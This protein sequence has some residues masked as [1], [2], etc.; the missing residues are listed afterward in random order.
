MRKESGSSGVLGSAYEWLD[1]IVTAMVLV[2]VL[3]TFVFGIVSVKGTS[4]ENTFMDTDKVIISNMFYTPQKGDVVI[5]SLNHTNDDS[6]S[7]QQ[8][9]DQRIIKRIIAVG[10]QKVRIDFDKGIVY[11]DGIAQDE[12]YTKTP[13]TLKYDL[14]FS[15]DVTVPE[16]HVF[17]MGDNRNGSIDSRSS[18]IGMIDQRYILGKVLFRFYSDKDYFSRF[19]PVS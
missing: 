4:M 14:D 7:A 15:E 16:G 9:E 11:V 12:P 6:L 3:F 17:V 2:V 1:S 10:G 13:T 19:G 18:E 5:V 8:D